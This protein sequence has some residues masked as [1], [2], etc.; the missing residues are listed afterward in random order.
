MPSR[1]DQIVDPH[2]PNNAHAH[3]L[4]LIGFNRRVLELGA[5][6][7]HVTRVLVEQRC[8]VTAIEFEPEAAADL[9]GLADRVICGDL[10]DPAVFDE[11]TAEYDVVLAGDVLEHLVRPHDVLCRAVRLLRPG[12][13]VVISLPH[14]GHVDVRLAL[15][16]GEWK[17][18][19]WGLLD[20]THVRFFTL[21]TIKEMLA[22]AGLTMT[23]LRRVR[24]PA[25]ESELDIAR[26]SVSSELLDELLSDPEAETY[27]FVLS[28]EVARRAVSVDGLPE[29]NAAL[30]DRLER[31]E[32]AYGALRAEHAEMTAKLERVD[33]ELAELEAARR[34]L[35]RIEGSVTWRYFQRARHGVFGALGGENSSGARAIQ[36]SLRR[37][38]ARPAGDRADAIAGH[39]AGA[40]P[41][42]RAGPIDVDRTGATDDRRAERTG[43]RAGRVRPPRGRRARARARRLRIAREPRCRASGPG[44]ATADVAHLLCAAMDPADR[45]TGR[46][47]H[48]LLRRARS[49]HGR[50]PVGRHRDRP[51]RGSVERT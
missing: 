24:M 9:G 6:A 19:P 4:A 35:A 39:R 33:E 27:Q 46:V 32:I 10:N 37:V 44:P 15:L 50:R 43:T 17:Y 22:D 48:V 21:P 29:R 40:A 31:T 18:R 5:A 28:A 23:E 2:R 30:Q 25:F 1:Y 7:G 49:A 12:G 36:A 14:V 41:G 11:L 34:T 38:G 13:H 26:D 45:Q 16:R 3:A 47:G 42:H 20:A 51:L 8:S